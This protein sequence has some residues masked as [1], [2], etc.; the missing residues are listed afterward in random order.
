MIFY[1]IAQVILPFWLVLAYDLLEDR[2]IDDDSA[3][4]KFSEFFEF[5]IW[6]NHNSLLSIA[7]NQFAWFCI[8]IRHV[9]PIFV[10]VKVAKFEIKRH[11]FSVYFNFLLYKTNRFHV[12]VR[13]FS[14]RSQRKSKC[15]KNISDTLGCASCATFLFLPH[16]DVICD[17]LLN[18][19]TATWNLFVKFMISL[20]MILFWQAVGHCTTPSYL[21]RFSTIP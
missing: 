19:R 18:R 8:D 6:T 3:R 17:L 20:S 10:S 1:I 21:L 9:S 13:L 5:W 12:A 15:G 4:F 7:T 11:F 2:R 16:F 14:N